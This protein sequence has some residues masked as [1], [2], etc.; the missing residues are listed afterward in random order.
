MKKYQKIVAV[1]FV[2]FGFFL[3]LKPSISTLKPIVI[4]KETSTQTL[5]WKLYKN[6]EYHF[7]F[8]YPEGLLSNFQVQMTNKVSQTLRQLSSLKKLNTQYDPN[9]YNVFFEVDGWKSSDS[10]PDFTKKYLPETKNQSRQT[11]I[12]GD[13]YGLRISNIDNSA[14][15]FYQY[16]LFKNGNYIYNFALL[17][18]ESI[19][20]GGNSKLLE[21]IIST[22][23]FGD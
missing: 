13:I 14:D 12:L 4:L 11:I 3:I 1:I 22:A 5:G 7:S 20:I 17:S 15:A 6:S 2:L 16:N 23:K 19:L 10:L 21:T 18:N 8:K 9:A